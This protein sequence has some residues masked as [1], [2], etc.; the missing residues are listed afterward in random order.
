MCGEPAEAAGS[1]GNERRAGVDVNF[2]RSAVSLMFAVNVC[3]M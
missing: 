3:I 1:A 2:A